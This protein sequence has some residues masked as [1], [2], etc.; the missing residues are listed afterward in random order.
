MRKVSNKLSKTGTQFPRAGL[1]CVK[2]GCHPRASDVDPEKEPG[3]FSFSD[4]NLNLLV[5]KHASL[6]TAFAT[7][8]NNSL[9][10]D[11]ICFLSF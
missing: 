9:F 11:K 4:H 10:E 3:Y 5:L 8:W 6:K 7:F 2:L 1:N